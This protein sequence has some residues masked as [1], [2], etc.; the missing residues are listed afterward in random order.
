MHTFTSQACYFTATAPQ[1]LQVQ[2]YPGCQ[3]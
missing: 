1:I 3:A 2:H